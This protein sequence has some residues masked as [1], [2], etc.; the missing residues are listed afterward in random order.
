MA[1]HFEL[2]KP[3]FSGTTRPAMDMSR[4]GFVLLAAL[5]VALGVGCRKK[6]DRD[7]TAASEPPVPS[8]SAAQSGETVA[9]MHWLGKKRLAAE[10][11]AAYFV[12]LW[13][14]PES[15]KL[16]AQTLDK[17][18]LAP[19]RLLKNDAA[20]NGAPNGLL[21]PLLDDLVQEESY[22]EVRHATNQPGETAL[23]IRLSAEEAALWQTN[24]AVVFESLTG[25]RATQ[26]KGGWSLKKHDAPNLIELAR[27][28]E[29]TM[30]GLSQ[31]TNTLLADL[32]SHVPR[33]GTPLST[34]NPQSSTNFWLT[35]DLDLRRFA[36]ALALSWSLPPGVPRVFLSMVGDGVNVHTRGELSFPKPL[37][38]ELEP[39]NIPTN[40]M[41]DPLTSFVAIR[42]IK[43]S[44][45]ALPFW[46]KL[47]LG[48]PPNQVCLWGLGATPFQTYFAAPTAEASNQVF[49]LG[50]WL[51]DEGNAWLSSNAMGRIAKLEGSNG[52]SWTGVPFMTPTLQSVA[53]PDGQFIKGGF[54]P[55]GSVRKPVPVELLY[56]INSRTNL[57]GYDWEITGARFDGWTGVG[58]ALRISLGSPRMPANSLGMTCL[59]AIKPKLGNSTTGVMLTGPSQLTFVR[60]SSIGFTA[61]ELHLLA[62]WL[63]SPQYPRGLHTLLA[64]PDLPWLKPKPLPAASSPP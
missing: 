50:E 34:V 16:E 23:A 42:G 8:K 17:L 4:T 60:S 12:S 51:L 49:R 10:T 24:L 44:L 29:W 6:P 14:L 55:A 7:Q 52:V 3:R 11:N 39:W 30:L 26:T 21:R 33:N 45:A 25:L 38:L 58:Q 19:W 1:D 54:F 37:G 9:R 46:Q 48:E 27:V 2:R 18:S 28:G 61:I 15:A 63:E 56:S 40:L 5:A 20:T 32:L 62:D 64:P 53:D 22:L 41:H 35:L 59:R 36:Q 31:E 43:P 47:K 57:V 13:N